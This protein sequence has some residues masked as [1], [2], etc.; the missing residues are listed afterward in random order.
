MRCGE[1][2]AKCIAFGQKC[3]MRCVDNVK[4]DAA[5]VAATTAVNMGKRLLWE[6]LLV[7]GF[8]KYNGVNTKLVKFAQEKRRSLRDEKATCALR[9]GMQSSHLM[10]YGILTVLFGTTRITKAQTGLLAE[11]GRST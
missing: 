7:V 2:D 5:Y 11:L 9:F 6:V 8:R 10:S 1:V 4:E 3:E